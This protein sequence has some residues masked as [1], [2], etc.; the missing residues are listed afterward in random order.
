[1]CY[2]LK[3][4]SDGPFVLYT[5]GAVAFSPSGRC[6]SPA[7]SN[8][9]LSRYQL[10]RAQPTIYCSHIQQSHMFVN[11]SSNHANNI[12]TR[13][14]SQGGRAEFV[15]SVQLPRPHCIN[16]RRFTL[17]ATHAHAR[18]PVP[19]P[20]L[21]AMRQHQT[22]R[23]LAVAWRVEQRQAVTFTFSLRAAM[24]DKTASLEKSA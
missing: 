23:K 13:G 8:M 9:L 1:M 7:A 11:A 12:K 19:P 20:P 2:Y 10:Q 3:S 17:W 16:P 14:V 4:P 15:L 6:S 24:M 5:A 22:L 18:L 21:D